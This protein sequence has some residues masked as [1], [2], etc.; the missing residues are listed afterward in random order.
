MSEAGERDRTLTRGESAL[1]LWKAIQDHPALIHHGLF[2]GLRNGK[3]FLEEDKE[4]KELTLSPD[5]FL[6]KNSNGDFSFPARVYLLGG[7]EVRWIE[8]DGLIQMLEVSFP[9]QSNILDRSSSLHSWKVRKS[10][11]NLTKRINRYY[12]IGEL[13]DLIPQRRGNS[14]R[15]VELLILGEETQAIAKGLKIR[16]V[17]GLRETLFVIDREFDDANKIT[18]FSFTGKGWG[19]GVGLCQIGAFGMAQAGAKYKEIL[20]KYYKDIK[21]SK[22][23]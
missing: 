23:Y 3:I 8:Q 15:V 4:E 9:R 7:E 18:H 19:H 12:P 10:N 1:Y 11:E 2:K 6:A 16:R 22:I 13:K 14:K 5:Y 21:I 20:K 17:L